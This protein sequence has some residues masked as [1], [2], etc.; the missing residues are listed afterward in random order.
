MSNWRTRRRNFLNGVVKGKKGRSG[1]KKKVPQYKDAYI[2]RQKRDPIKK[3]GL[4]MN[5]AGGGKARRLCRKY[6]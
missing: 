1:E 5:K 2:C 4:Q 3:N 6:L